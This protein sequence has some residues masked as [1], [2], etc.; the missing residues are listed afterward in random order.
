MVKL[1]KL[2]GKTTLELNRGEF[3]SLFCPI[4]KDRGTCLKLE[5]NVGSCKVLVDSGLWWRWLEI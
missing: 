2:S 5:E 1:N 3:I 4:C